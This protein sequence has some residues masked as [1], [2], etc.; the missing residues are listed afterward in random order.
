MSTCRYCGAHCVGP[1]CSYTHMRKWYWK[2]ISLKRVAIVGLVVAALVSPV[3][4][5]EAEDVAATCAREGGCK[6]V[7]QKAYIVFLEA[8]QA[9]VAE[10]KR[11]KEMV[12]QIRKEQCA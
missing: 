9:A 3:I 1:F 7:T 4:A 10:T 6:L 2:R 12:K 11:L 8:Y 5:D